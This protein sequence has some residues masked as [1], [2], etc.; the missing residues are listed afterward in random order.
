LLDASCDR[1]CAARGPLLQFSHA[2]FDVILLLEHAQSGCR[3][4]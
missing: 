1:A 3:G 4:R 2:V